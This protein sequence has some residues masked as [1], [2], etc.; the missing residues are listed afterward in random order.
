MVTD[1]TG[2]DGCGGREG[3]RCGSC[4]NEGHRSVCLGIRLGLD[5]NSFP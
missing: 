4:G 2:G 1:L 3:Q 5:S